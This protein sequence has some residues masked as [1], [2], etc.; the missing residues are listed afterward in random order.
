MESPATVQFAGGVGDSVRDWFVENLR[1]M[2]AERGY[3]SVDEQAGA[4]DDARG[5]ALH[6]IDPGAPRGYRR[7]SRAIFVVGVTAVDT[8]PAHVLKVAY[9]L[10]VRSLS[11]LFILLVRSGPGDPHPEAHFVT[12]ERGH[13]T[14]RYQGDDRT[15]FE[16]VLD[17]LAPLA[18]SQLV[19][20]NH[21]QADLPEELWEG[22][23]YTAAIYRAGR[24][25]D[26]M[27]LLPAPVPIQ[28]LLPPRDYRHVQ[29]LFG[30]GGLSYGNVSAR[31]DAETFWMSA[32]GVDKSHLR[33]VG[34]EILLVTGYD[35]ER[36]AIQ[37]RVPP[38]VQPRRV[39]V[40]AIE[41]LMIYR[42]HPAVGAIL[43]IHAWID[44]IASTEVNYPCGTIELAQAV[45]DL[46]RESPD[47]TRAVIGL[48]N[49]GL[50][51]TGPNLD[52]ILE[53]IE[54]RVS[55]D[56]PMS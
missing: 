21:F 3:T 8:I 53:R 25:M 19:I 51:I 23:E 7:K 35:T 34:E 15:F 46:V 29:R 33:V 6:P 31:R 1:I 50:T 47:P 2:M 43:H 55:R 32:S 44:G 9:P 22:D 26:A 14:L 18:T 42:E 45:A 30:L 54:S 10:L 39:S 17:R 41:H 49:H 56:V 40:D 36:G 48:K 11:N 52:E 37:L 16:G 27:Q 38:H 28:E 20:D 4:G 13:Y 12:L 24:W 5:V